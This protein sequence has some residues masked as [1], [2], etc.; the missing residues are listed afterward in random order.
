MDLSK[1]GPVQSLQKL[2]FSSV[3]MRYCSHREF[4]IS[5]LRNMSMVPVY[6]LHVDVGSLKLAG[7]ITGCS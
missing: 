6:T 3:S 5:N 2:A 1:T 4:D 7:V